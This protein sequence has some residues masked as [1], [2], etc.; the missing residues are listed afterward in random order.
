MVDWVQ[1]DIERQRVSGRRLLLTVVL[2]ILLAGA[3]FA[4]AV[5]ALRLATPAW[6]RAH[7]GDVLGGWLMWAYLAL[8]SSLLLCFGG[9]SGLRRTLGFRYTSS[10]DL[11]LAFIT[12]AACFF[13]GIA[14]TFALTPL[15]GQPA[16][17]TTALLSTSFDPLF[18]GLVVPTV[19]LLAPAC[20]ELLFR[21][22]LYG[23]VRRRLPP[24]AAIPLVA[25]VFAGA[26]AIVPLM[27]TLFVFGLGAA[28]LRERTGSTLN[29]F[30]M[31]ATQ[32]TVAVIGTYLVLA[33]R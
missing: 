6:S 1:M 4:L 22:A 3:G 12:W 5:A 31:H 28:W 11:A 23:W 29:S 32:N 24:L 2:W 21:G 10:G 25:L 30:A 14:L 19:C 9:R 7:R 18:V 15:L 27:P 26:H 8:L 13:A 33:H 16:S 20:E 17:N